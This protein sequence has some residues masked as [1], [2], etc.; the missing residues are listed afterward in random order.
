MSFYIYPLSKEAWKCCEGSKGFLPWKQNFSCISTFSPNLL[1]KSLKFHLGLYLM[2]LLSF[3]HKMHVNYAFSHKNWIFCLCLKNY[4]WDI[5]NFKAI[6]FYER[7]D[8]FGGL[9]S[10]FLLYI[11]VYV[12]IYMYIKRKF[13]YLQIVQNYLFSCLS[14]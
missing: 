13:L 10:F 12:Y 9:L 11:C 14:V 4:L 7:R 5:Y 8:N 2:E 6:C 1:R 3:S